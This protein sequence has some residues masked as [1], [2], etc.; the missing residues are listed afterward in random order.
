MRFAHGINWKKNIDFALFIVTLCIFRDIQLFGVQGVSS[1][2][3]V[4]RFKL[5][6]KTIIAF[7]EN[8]FTY[9]EDV[10]FLCA[11]IFL[12]VRNFLHIMFYFPKVLSDLDLY[13]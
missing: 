1:S 11:A 7:P 2:N 9:T 3:Q 8:I 10:L 12:F 13:L 6:K 4:F 5:K